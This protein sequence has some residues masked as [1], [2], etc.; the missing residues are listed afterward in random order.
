MSNENKPAESENVPQVENE[1][2]VSSPVADGAS[3]LPTYESINSGSET[4]VN[5]AMIEKR[6]AD[7][8]AASGTNPSGEKQNPRS[9]SGPLSRFRSD[10]SAPSG[11]NR[12]KDRPQSGSGG[13]QDKK[14]RSSTSSKRDRTEKEDSRDSHS[15]RRGESLVYPD[16][17][18]TTIPFTSLKGRFSDD[19]EQ[20]LNDLFEDQPLDMIIN[21]SLDSLDG[22][23]VLEE[24]TKVKARIIALQ[25]DCVF[26][27]VGAREQGI[28]PL[29]QFPDEAVLQIG[30][31]VDAVISRFNQ[32]E[33]MYDVSLPMAALEVGD[34]SSV[35]AGMI[36]EAR[37][38]GANKGGLEC[39]VGR[40]RAFL[41]VSQIATF[42]V[43]NPEEFIGEKWKC[44]ITESNPDRRNLVLSRRALME[45]EREELR[46]Q[47]LAELEPGQIREGMVRKI[48]DVGAFVDL[49]GVDGFIPI[50]AMSWGRI[51]HPTAVLKEGDRVKVKVGKIDRDR[52]RISLVLRD[53]AMDPW[54]RVP[55][56]YSVNTEVRGRIAK[57]LPIGAFI[58][59]M[60]GIDGFVHISEISYKRIGAVTDVLKEGEW[61]LTK[62]LSIDT[63]NRKIS[64]SIKQCG[65]DPREEEKMVNSEKNND[66]EMTDQPEKE[67]I[68]EKVK[69]QLPKGP[70]KGGLGGNNQGDHFGLKW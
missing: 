54:Y 37:V 44:I 10:H 41:P 39:E 7:L 2:S 42:R 55:D 62:I 52:N 4:V 56:L 58:E 53:E 68:P 70:L 28:I 19:E 49:G 47:I 11:G 69:N 14:D 63:T 24:G 66:D 57:I 67:A 17:P 34:W 38:V 59:L 22:Q 15:S 32:E 45:K 8:A 18:A 5:S 30:D 50:S 51:S 65:P 60:P 61:V 21:G 9:G 40:I 13:S 1:S 27:N 29:K 26:V 46:E 3:P 36:V 12:Q 16:R 64:L 31:L 25:K 43:E 48:I 23:E 20:E 33:G 6:L 35:S